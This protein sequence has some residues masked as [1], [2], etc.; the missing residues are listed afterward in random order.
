MELFSWMLSGF[1]AVINALLLYMLKEFGKRISAV[2]SDIIAFKLNY[3]H[4]FE[5]AADDRVKLER[6]LISAINDMKIENEKSHGYIIAEFN[7]HK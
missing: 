6:V 3:I 2:E 4:R 1:L 5:M 7:K